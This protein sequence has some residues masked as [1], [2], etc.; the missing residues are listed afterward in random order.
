MSL[1][2]EC[3]RCGEHL[4]IVDEREGERRLSSLKCDCGGRFTRGRFTGRP[5][6]METYRLL[7][8][9]LDAEY[10]AETAL[11]RHGLLSDEHVLAGEILRKA[12][13][14]WW[15]AHRILETGV[16]LRAELETK[17]SA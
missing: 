7:L 8:S 10:R 4:V 16:R 17:E 1:T 13:A 2:A 15:K 6:P 11:V 3:E 14:E 5:T 12:R 9:L